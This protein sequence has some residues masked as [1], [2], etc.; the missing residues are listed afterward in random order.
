M[1][2]AV[3][4]PAN[5]SRLRC[6]IGSRT[7]ACTPL[8]KARPLSRLY[9][10]SS[11]TSSSALRMAS[12]RGAFIGEKLRRWGTSEQSASLEIRRFEVFSFDATNQRVAAIILLSQ[13]KELPNEA[14][15][16][17]TRENPGQRRRARA[18]WCGA[19]PLRHRDPRRAAARRAFVEDRAR[20][21][22][23]AVGRAD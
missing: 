18:A 15:T 13:I 3:F 6:S 9:L 21:A 1:K 19:R 10:S 2:P 5:A 23:R 17:Q 22:H 4:K 7:S 20:V 14:E 11:V 16:E 12:G 8:V